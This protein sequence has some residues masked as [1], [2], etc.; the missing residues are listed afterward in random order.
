MRQQYEE[1]QTVAAQTDGDDE[2]AA[3]AEAATVNLVKAHS[4]GHFIDIDPEYYKS[5]VRPRLRVS[6]DPAAA[7]LATELDRRFGLAGSSR[8]EGSQTAAAQTDDGDVPAA[9]AEAATVNLVKAHSAGHFIDIDPEY[10]K[11]YI[12]SRLRA[13]ADPAAAALATELDRRFGLAG[14][15]P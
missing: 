1:S 4:A 5:Y 6:A 15:S 9:L 10:Y 2:P 12:R 13:S 11:S 8:Y 7:A 3:R 14:S